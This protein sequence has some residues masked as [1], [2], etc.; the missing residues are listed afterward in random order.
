[1]VRAPNNPELAICAVMPDGSY[2]L[3]K[4]IINILNI[5]QEYIAIRANALRRLLNGTKFDIDEIIYY[6]SYE[7]IVQK[8][9]Y[10]LV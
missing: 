3:T 6:N 9:C 5:S 7:D 10:F 1:M 8:H 2:F 4:E